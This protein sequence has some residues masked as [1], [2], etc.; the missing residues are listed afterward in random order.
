MSDTPSQLTTP[1]GKPLLL[2]AAT[3]LFILLAMVASWLVF[4]PQ[5]VA[6]GLQ[7]KIQQRTGLVM[8]LVGPVRL[9]FDKGLV[10]GMEDVSLAQPGG[11]SVPLLTVDR[12]VLPLSI[13]GIFAG[14]STAQEVYLENPVVALG[15]D[16]G[17]KLLGE[18]NAKSDGAIAAKENKP[19]KIVIRNGAI[20]MRFGQSGVGF[21]ASDLDGAIT[22]DAEQGLAARLSG[23]FNGASTQF[24]LALD[25]GWRALAE[26]S[27]AEISLSTSGNQVAFS[28]RLR[29]TDRLMLDGRIQGHGD[30]LGDFCNWLSCNIKGFS[31][32]GALDFDS[33]LSLAGDVAALREIKL[34]LGNMKGSGEVSLSQTATRPLIDVKLDFDVFDLAAYQHDKSAGT[35]VPFKLTQ[36]WSE[37]PLDFAD[38]GAFDGNLEVT[39]KSM[40]FAGLLTGPAKLDLRL[41]DKKLNGGLRA[42]KVEGG[43]FETTFS[44]EGD[45]PVPQLAIKVTTQ[46]VEARKFLTSVLGF[47][48]IEGPMN[49][50]A[51]VTAEGLHVAGLIS[52]LGGEVAIKVAKGRLHGVDLGKSLLGSGK[53]WNAD[54]QND[55]SLTTL[56]TDLNVDMTMRDGIAKIQTAEFTASGFGVAATGEV[57]ILRQHVDLLAKPVIVG[58][59]NDFKLPL[60]IKIAGAWEAPDINPDVGGSLL[61]PALRLINK[62][63]DDVGTSDD[64]VKIGKKAKKTLKKLFGN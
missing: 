47:S 50:K 39:S 15:A 44:L 16:K 31:A 55:A 59:Q 14:G 11:Q 3:L 4:L 35:A 32:S 63:S 41:K 18:I 24:E 25:D 46:E 38:L 26:G 21:N 13:A 17:D 57:D 40:H 9:G 61:K 33:A 6:V 36:G 53:I 23:L 56:A 10:V 20:K 37:R 1:N 48:G 29:S 12:M 5:R 52:T 28:G 8:D 27:P 58:G 19:F 62:A 43:R 34:G 60:Q 64:L 49:L 2:V 22:W 54:G 51:D 45:G 30:S 42:E 7:D